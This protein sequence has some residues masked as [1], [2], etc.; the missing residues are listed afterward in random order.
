[1]KD[2]LNGLLTTA[3]DRA[4]YRERLV[5]SGSLICEEEDSC[6]VASADTGA[7]CDV[8]G[9]LDVTVVDCRYRFEHEGGHIK[10]STSQPCSV[11]FLQGA[12]PLPPTDLDASDSPD[13]SD[14]RPHPRRLQR[15][16][17][18]ASPAG[19]SHQPLHAPTSSDSTQVFVFHC[20]F[21]AN[22]GP[23]MARRLRNTDRH[24]HMEHFPFLAHPHLYVLEGGYKAFHALA[25]GLCSTGA[26]VPMLH[27]TF[28]PKLPS[29]HAAS[30][31]AARAIS[32]WVRGAATSPAHSPATQD[33]SSSGKRG[34]KRRRSRGA[35]ADGE[36]PLYMMSP[37]PSAQRS[38]GLGAMHL[39]F[40]AAGEE[41]GSAKR[42]HHELCLLSTRTPLP[43]APSG[44]SLASSPAPP[45]AVM[46]EGATAQ[47]DSPGPR[48]DSPPSALL[49]A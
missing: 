15:L 31:D 9:D 12:F 33:S 49:F 39:S 5:A 24:L 43:T 37:P 14:P 22:R 16:H 19:H 1:M 46:A 10:G 48:V 4:A 17:Q 36:S 28:L 25:P 47:P 26:Y 45:S 40:T 30:K 8:Q 41:G 32:A 42:R 21:S 23:D 29:A 38:R 18:L 35:R 6:S 11:H 34:L 13:S 44:F 27:P 2:L 7:D 20:E 3:A